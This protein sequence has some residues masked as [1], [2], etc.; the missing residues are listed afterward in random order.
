MKFTR[1]KDLETSVRINIAILA[2]YCQGVYGARTEL[3]RQYKVSRSVSK[4][5]YWSGLIQS[6][7]VIQQ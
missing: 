3:A 4:S 6:A 5:T 1:R 7:G 2:L